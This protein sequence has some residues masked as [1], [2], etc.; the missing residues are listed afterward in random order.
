MPCMG[1]PKGCAPFVGILQGGWPSCRSGRGRLQ[2]RA[3]DG[4]EAYTNQDVDRSSGEPAIAA[5]AFTNNAGSASCRSHDQG[6]QRLGSA[7]EVLLL[8]LLDLPGL[9]TEDIQRGILR[10]K[11][12]GGN[13]QTQHD[14][15]PEGQETDE[16]A[17]PKKPG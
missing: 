14:Q 16:L 4:R 17:P 9:I 15:A 12:Q 2:S 8:F 5:E 10:S 1:V 11:E 3:C 6:K 13:G 7:M